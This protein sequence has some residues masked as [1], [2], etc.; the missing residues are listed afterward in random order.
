MTLFID[1]AVFMYAAGADHE[2]RGPCQAV[3]RG[4]VERRIDAV[5]SAEVVQEVLHRYLSIRQVTVGIAAAR[6]ILTAFGPVLPVTHDV[7]ARVPDLADRYA[8][9][10]AARDLVHLASCIEAGI[11]RIVTTDH[12]FDRITEVRR[13]D[14]RELAA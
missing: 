5:T 10:L 12:G 4:A 9:R 6:D 1:S 11:D 2:L 8:D 3:L 13:V 14:P 7:M